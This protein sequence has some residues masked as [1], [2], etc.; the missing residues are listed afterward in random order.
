MFELYHVDEYNL[1]MYI[2]R[3]LFQ[4]K[5]ITIV[6]YG[7]TNRDIGKILNHASSIWRVRLCD[8]CYLLVD[9]WQVFKMEMT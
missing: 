2:A 1:R 6:N 7:S 5:M 3:E 4:L 8:T 9:K